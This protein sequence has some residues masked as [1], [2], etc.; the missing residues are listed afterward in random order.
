MRLDAD[1]T[2]LEQVACYPLFFPIYL[3]QFEHT[4]GDNNRVF[5]V[6]LDAHDENVSTAARRRGDAAVRHGARCRDAPC[7]GEVLM[8]PGEPLPSE[9]ACAAGDDRA[10]RGAGLPCVLLVAT[11]L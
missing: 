4:L 6:V 2:T 8:T 7:G 1:A 3:A 11:P 5:T 9:L 10:V